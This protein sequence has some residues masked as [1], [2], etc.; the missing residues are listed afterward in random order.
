LIEQVDRADEGL[1]A[2]GK[3]SPYQSSLGGCDTVAPAIRSS[4]DR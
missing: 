1:I 2:A 3:G 4:Q